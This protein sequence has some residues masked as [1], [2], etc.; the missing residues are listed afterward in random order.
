MRYFSDQVSEAN[1]AYKGPSVERIARHAD[2]IVGRSI[3]DDFNYLLKQSIRGTCSEPRD[4]LYAIL[5]LVDDSGQFPVDYE[6]PL[7]QILIESLEYFSSVPGIPNNFGLDYH[8]FA[9]LAFFNTAFGVSCGCAC[10]ECSFVLNGNQSMETSMK[11]VEPTPLDTRGNVRSIEYN[12]KERKYIITA[13][14]VASHELLYA[15]TNRQLWRTQFDLGDHIPVAERRCGICAKL[16]LRAATS[17]HGWWQ[18]SP[19]F[20]GPAPGCHLQLGR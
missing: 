16:F 4:H 2:G 6:Q 8:I 12:N 10:E 15:Q 20:T 1:K 3:S 17:T 14:T 18:Y 7:S 5:G 19:P 11:S 9:R 13:F